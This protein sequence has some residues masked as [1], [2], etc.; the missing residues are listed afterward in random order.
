[1]TDEV[2]ALVVL[3]AFLAAMA[4]VRFFKTL[5]GGFWRAAGTP[6]AAGLVAGAAIAYIPLPRFITTGILL[7]LVSL[8]VRLTGE[9]SEPTD[10][11]IL[12]ALSGAAAAL[13][14][15]FLLD[16]GELRAVSE[17]L[18]AGAVA[19]YG[20]TFASLHV[21]DKLRQLMLDAVT[22]VVAIGAAYL[23]AFGRSERQTAILV[24]AAIPLIVVITVLRQWPDMRAELRHEASLGFI[25]DADVRPTAHPLLRLGRGGWADPR[26]H[27]KFVRLANK[28][29][30]RKRKQRNRP[31]ETARL[32][33]L[34]IIKLRMQLQEMSKIDRDMRR[35]EAPEA[36]QG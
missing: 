26:A 21:A 5:D 13:P 28:I 3:L 30:L 4:A 8:Y 16:A 25:D 31:D 6:I 36:H 1:V 10:G 35:G 24:A 15:A 18:L 14:L 17:C 9:E 34:E 20:I 12:G 7:T 23:P 27:R 29:A 22:A 32:Y 11:M 2:L 19:G 33:Q